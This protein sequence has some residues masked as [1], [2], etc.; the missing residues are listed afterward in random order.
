MG[1]PHLPACLPPLLAVP[2]HLLLLLLALV[3]AFF[4]SARL[5]IA[6]LLLRPPA[7]STSTSPPSSFSSSSSSRSSRASPVRSGTVVRGAS[8]VGVRFPVSAFRRKG[9]V[10][11]VGITRPS[12]RETV[13]HLCSGLISVRAARLVWWFVCASTVGPKIPS[14]FRAVTGAV[15]SGEKIWLEGLVLANKHHTRIEC[16]APVPIDEIRVWI[17]S[18][19]WFHQAPLDSKYRFQ[20]QGFPFEELSLREEEGKEE[21]VNGIAVRK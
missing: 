12:L 20:G 10:L 19:I 2:R 14:S 6:A 11:S 16:A 4:C 8:G 18:V 1:A 15:F 13:P 21:E 5:V 9:W 3:P 7:V 17:S